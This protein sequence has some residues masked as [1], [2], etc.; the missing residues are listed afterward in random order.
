MGA[1][2]FPKSTP[3]FSLRFPGRLCVL[4]VLISTA[5]GN[6]IAG[7]NSNDGAT[8]RASVGIS[9]NLGNPGQQTL[10]QSKGEP[11]AGLVTE[12]NLPPLSRRRRQ[13][14]QSITMKEGA[15]AIPIPMLYNNDSREVDPADVEFFEQSVQ[16]KKPEVL[17]DAI[18]RAPVHEVSA[19]DD[20]RLNFRTKRV[21]SAIN[22]ARNGILGVIN[23][24]KTEVLEL[25]LTSDELL[26]RVQDLNLAGDEIN[27]TFDSWVSSTN[28]LQNILDRNYSTYDGVAE[29]MNVREAEKKQHIERL[30][31][32]AI[33]EESQL[34]KMEQAGR[35]LEKIKEESNI[36]AAAALAKDTRQSAASNRKVVVDQVLKQVDEKALKLKQDIEEHSFLSAQKDAGA[37]LLT[38]VK[39]DDFGELDKDSPSDDKTKRARTTA[40]QMSYL[41]DANNNKYALIRPKD[42]TIMPDDLLLMN[43]LI[44]ILVSCFCAGLLCSLVGLPP[45]V[46]YMLTGM[47]LGPAGLNMMTSLVQISTIGELGVLFI[48]FTLGLEFSIAKLQEV[49]RVAVL[50]GSAMLFFTVCSGCTVGVFLQRDFGETLYVSACIGLSSTALVIK[51]MSATEAEA[52]FG[53][54]LM[55]ILLIQ[56]VYLGAIVATTSLVS[57]QGEMTLLAGIFMVMQLLVSMF[58]VVVVAALSTKILKLLL[59]A[60]PKFDSSV[61]ILAL[62]SICFVFMALTHILGISNELGCFIA[63]V[64]ISATLSV[65]EGSAHHHNFAVPLMVPV[66]DFFVCIFFTSVGTHLYPSFLLANAWLLLSLTIATMLLKYSVCFAVW[67]LVWRSKDMASGHMI[68]AGLCQISEFSFVLASRGTRMGLI[69]QPIYFL[70]V[71]VGGAS[72]LL[73]PAVWVIGRKTMRY[74]PNA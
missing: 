55:G 48:L 61:Q 74:L 56:D 50:C 47:G 10:R 28:H 1:R 62:L 11:K 37:R 20:K 59:V 31:I 39:I 40:G 41:F 7:A 42:T 13:D 66:Q 44:V 38:V 6:A 68:S 57:K 18:D 49:W 3:R 45:L 46:G 24:H 9:Q 72:L 27:S 33:K 34:K 15:A 43:D 2:L 52:S 26:A 54:S 29:H 51:S 67:I 30:Q 73:S 17:K 16:L 25:N 70:L 53:R 14:D 4:A 63:G 36:H 69:S 32:E 5:Q 22:E 64:T 19:F 23:K 60:L 65:R 21:L 35:M 71:S 58:F 8:E 12:Q